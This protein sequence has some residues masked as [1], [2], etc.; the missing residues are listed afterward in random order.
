MIATIH[1][2]IHPLRSPS[3]EGLYR[4][5]AVS[6]DPSSKYRLLARALAEPGARSRDQHLGRDSL[7]EKFVFLELRARSTLKQISS[8]DR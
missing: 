7:D 3:S 4:K 2:V 5:E 1:L 6:L 8:R